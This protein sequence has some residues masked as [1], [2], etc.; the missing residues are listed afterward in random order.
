MQA[1]LVRKKIIPWIALFLL[2]EGRLSQAK[3]ARLFRGRRH[4]VFA[5]I[6][7]TRLKKPAG[8]FAPD[9][10]PITSI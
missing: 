3:P 10:A 1:S 6:I 4:M 8:L 7:P 5:S 2:P 9:D